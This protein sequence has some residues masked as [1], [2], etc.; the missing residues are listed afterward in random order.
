MSASKAK[1]KLIVSDWEGPWVV[2]DFAYDIMNALVPD[3]DRLFSSISEYDDYLAYI[4]KKRG[5]EPGDTLA[6][7]APFL[8][9]YNI[10]ETSLQKVASDSAN[11]LDGSIDAI[12]I[13]HNLGYPI[14]IVSTSYSQYVWL[15][16][17]EAGIKRE[18]TKSTSFP[19]GEF[20]KLVKEK[21]KTRVK[22]IIP[23]I[24][25]LGRLGISASSTD[26]DL[27][28]DARKTINKLDEFF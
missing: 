14:R 20:K 19:I 23:E 6:L 7:I 18:H 3:G 26:K 15:T 13:L 22:E 1:K 12:K 27:R 10:D 25:K 4:R 17:S 24:L 21:D 28:P 11:F 2:A 9:A 5:Y 16:T 8:I